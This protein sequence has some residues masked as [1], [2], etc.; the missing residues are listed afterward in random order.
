MHNIVSK[1][2]IYGNMPK[3]S[4]LIKLSNIIKDYKE[5]KKENS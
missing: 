5:S 4:I 3:D 2:I 1:L